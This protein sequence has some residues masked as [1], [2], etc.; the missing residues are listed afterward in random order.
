MDTAGSWVAGKV[1]I[2]TGAARGLGAAFA[3]AL[4]AQGAALALC[5]V[6]DDVRQ[7]GADLAARH[8]VDV[9]AW[10]ADVRRPSDV[11]RVVD[12]TLAAFGRVD[13]L[14]N[15]AGI[16]AGSPVDEAAD[17][18][19]A[20]F[21]DV[22]AV[23]TRAPF[24]FG[25]AVMPPMLAQGDGHIVNIVTDHVYTEP[26][27]PTGGGPGMD[28]YDASKWALNGFTLAWSAALAGTVRVNG[29]CMGATDTWMLRSFWGGDP[30]PDVS[31]RWKRPAD[32]AALL[33]ELIEEGPAGRSGWNLPVWVDD[34]IVMPPAEADWPVRVGA[35]TAIG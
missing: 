8:G 17:V 25:R 35:I 18:A 21:Q 24:L 12:D 26:R 4:A 7:V 34:P 15:N 31:A 9:H 13:V 30:P 14:V 32:V 27:R 33:V 2:V 1:A 23:N 11:W 28:V 10:V 20:T 5:D 29:I 22:V 3:D 19:S 16:W 6:L